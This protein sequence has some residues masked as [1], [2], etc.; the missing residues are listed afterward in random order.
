MAVVFHVE[1][2]QFPHVARAFNLSGEELHTRFVAPWVAGALIDYEER[3]WAPDRAK[4]TILEGPAVRTEELGLGRGWAVAGRS[5][6]D[7]T[8]TMIA[9]ARRGSEARPE[10]E[11]LK[12]AVAEVAIHAVAFQDVMALAAAAHPTWRP[13]EQLAL[14][15]QA[16]W[17]MLHQQRLEMLAGGEPV[18]RERW[19]AY[20]LSWASWV[21]S[22]DTVT[23]IMR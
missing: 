11:V 3:R 8:E 16:V 13:S 15:E 14:A 23:L 12:S 9:H 1:L 6:A 20:V 21:S 4:L 18:P 7:V 22:A 17:E 5:C 19:Q 10:L 2:R